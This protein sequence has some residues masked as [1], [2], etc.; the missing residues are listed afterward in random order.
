MKKI[1]NKFLIGLFFMLGLMLLP[2]YVGAADSMTLTVL[3][4]G[5]NSEVIPYNG[6][7]TISWYATGAASCHETLGRGGNLPTGSFTV[8]NVTA[9]TNFVVTCTNASYCSGNYT[10]TTIRV[11]PAGKSCFDD[12]GIVTGCPAPYNGACGSGSFS[13]LSPTDFPWETGNLYTPVPENKKLGDWGDCYDCNDAGYV[14]YE[15]ISGNWYRR[16]CV[17]QR[18]IICLGVRWTEGTTYISP[19]YETESCAGLSESSCLSKSSSGCTWNL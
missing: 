14:G 8:N 19:A 13:C 11:P 3:A 15:V 7:V 17:E 9:N 1:F 4:N 18:F 2:A 6:S 5:K 10:D 12:W 16:V